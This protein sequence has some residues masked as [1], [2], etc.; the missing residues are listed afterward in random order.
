MKFRPAWALGAVV[1]L[2]VASLAAVRYIDRIPP[3]RLASLLGITLTVSDLRQE[4]PSP[5][6]RVSPATNDRTALRGSVAVQTFL[7]SALVRQGSG[8]VVSADGLILTTTVAAPYGS[9]SYVYQIA[10]SRGQLL[11]AHRVLSDR[12]S[13]LV[14]LKAD[15]VDLDAVLFD[16][17][18]DPFVAG[19]QL[20]AVASQVQI[21]TFTNQRLP[22][23]VAWASPDGQITVSLDRVL[24][25][26][27][28][29]ARVIDQYGHSLGIILYSSSSPRVV[30]ASAINTFL[31][32]YLARAVPF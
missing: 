2:A 11:R 23:W 3:Q 10:T 27:F 18:A 8:T 24:G 1:V 28:H 13:G 25:Y 22:L 16:T 6:P 29:G 5:S 14:L 31:E 4:S 26:A 19:Q 30:K 17:T 20:E 7:G 9:G 12:V 32:S 21:S 15:A